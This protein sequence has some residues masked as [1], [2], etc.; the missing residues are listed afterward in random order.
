MMKLISLDGNPFI[1]VYAAAGEKVA[2]LPPNT[3]D[4]F[5]N[6]IRGALG[7]EIITGTLGDSTV[8]GSL[9]AMN[10]SG[11]LVTPFARDDEIAPL[12]EFMEVR[13]LPGKYSAVGNNV[14]VNNVGAVV[15]PSIRKSHY[16]LIKDVFDVEV[17]KMTIG[18]IDT[19]GSACLVNDKGGLC[20]PKVTNEELKTLSDFFGIPFTPGTLNYGT[21]YVG[22]C[23]LAN[24]KGAVIGDSSTPIEMGKVEDALVLY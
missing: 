4:A 10:S 20:H 13:R 14:L 22:A 1:G 23:A 11:A 6:D 12:K 5:K 16:Q 9:I 21:G 17:I 8:V 2:F 19:V 24:S 18:G 3:P 7:V 15:N